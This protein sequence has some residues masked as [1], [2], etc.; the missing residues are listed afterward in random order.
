M[1]NIFDEDSSGYLG[2]STYRREIE[3]AEPGGLMN[4]PDDVIRLH[5]L[6]ENVGP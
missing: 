3:S 1:I 5:P 4:A 2:Q 6:F